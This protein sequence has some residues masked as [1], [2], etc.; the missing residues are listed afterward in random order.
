MSGLI[1]ALGL[2][3][4]GLALPVH[5]QAVAPSVLAV[6]QEHGENL[7]YRTEELLRRSQTGPAEQFI[8]ALR[9]LGEPAGELQAQLDAT[10]EAHPEFAA[11]GGPSTF[12]DAFYSMLRK[13]PE[14]RRSAV[15]L[16]TLLAAS[17]NRAQLTGFLEASADPTV[18]AMLETRQL[19]GWQ[20]LY[21]VDV[22]GG[23]ALDCGFY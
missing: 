13:Q 23:A 2:V 22:P 17:D 12:F 3:L 1:L 21:P 16:A 19:T 5:Y 4:A 9:E 20:R 7:D 14:T 10:L 6:A 15:D 18:S 8:T 11:S